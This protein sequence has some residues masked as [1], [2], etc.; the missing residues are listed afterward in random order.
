MQLLSA[1]GV[2]ER[3]EVIFDLVELDEAIRVRVRVRVRPL[4]LP[5]APSRPLQA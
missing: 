2:L 4:A 5:R 1:C 3:V